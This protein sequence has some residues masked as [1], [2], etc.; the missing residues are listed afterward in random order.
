MKKSTMT[1][2]R[3]IFLVMLCL[4]GVCV[5]PARASVISDGAVGVISP[6]ELGYKL[7]QTINSIKEGLHPVLVVLLYAGIIFVA[8][9]A[10]AAL[11]ISLFFLVMIFR[12]H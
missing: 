10:F 1:H 4:G 8:F 2:I 9:I 7:T 5:S 11:V 12:R 3:L 6:A